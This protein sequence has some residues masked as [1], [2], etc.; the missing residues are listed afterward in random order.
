VRDAFVATFARL[1]LQS[2]GLLDDNLY[3][4]GLHG[5]ALAREQV[6]DIVVEMAGQED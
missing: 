4:L 2:R 1:E 6:V 3:R 5:N